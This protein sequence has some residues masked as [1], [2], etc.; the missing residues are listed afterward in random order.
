MDIP[1]VEGIDMIE[2]YDHSMNHRLRKEGMNM[3]GSHK[4]D[5]DGMDT[6]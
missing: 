5:V 3:V 2:E 4:V 6:V 1:E